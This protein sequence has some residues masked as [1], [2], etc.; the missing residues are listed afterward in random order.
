MLRNLC[1][2]QDTPPPPKPKRDASTGTEQIKTC[3]CLRNLKFEH[4]D[5]VCHATP[6]RIAAYNEMKMLLDTADV[7]CGIYRAVILISVPTVSVADIIFYLMNFF[8][9]QN[10]CDTESVPGV[11]SEQFCADVPEAQLINSS[12]QKNTTACQS[13]EVTF[14]VEDSAREESSIKSSSAS[15]TAEGPV[16]VSVMGDVST[17]QSKFLGCI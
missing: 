9:V 1:N 17:N 8:D 15:A 6:E 10:D 7:A 4:R 2:L 14:P 11:S 16:K 13:T 3:Y 5:G 12:R